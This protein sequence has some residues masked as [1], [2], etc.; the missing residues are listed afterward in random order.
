MVNR[1]I[2]T[3]WQNFFSI[4]LPIARDDDKYLLCLLTYHIEDITTVMLPQV[5]GADLVGTSFTL[6]KLLS[7]ESL[8]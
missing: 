2:S 3:L 5:Q 7:A 8:S 1:F 4:H 6:G